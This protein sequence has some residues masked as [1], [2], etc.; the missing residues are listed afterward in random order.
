ME[1]HDRY[2]V[3]KTIK[4]EISERQNVPGTVFHNVYKQKNTKSTDGS[5]FL[6]WNYQPLAK[7]IK[8]VI[9]KQLQKFGHVDEHCKYFMFNLESSHTLVLH[10]RFVCLCF[11]LRLGMQR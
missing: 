8:I 7:H 5:D 11:W 10:L 3:S 6:G 4:E 9:S 2:L 1:I